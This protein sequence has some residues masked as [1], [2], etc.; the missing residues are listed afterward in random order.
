MKLLSEVTCV[1]DDMEEALRP[2]R[3]R[4]LID[5][6]G[7]SCGAVDEH[8]TS[9]LELSGEAVEENLI[10]R[11]GLS[12]EAVEEHFIVWAGALGRLSRARLWRNLVTV[13]FFWIGFGSA[14]MPR[15]WTFSRRARS[16]RR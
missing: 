8:F 1:Q 16:R 14:W 4:S 10:D 9:G 5:R 11:L 3:D 7:L 6:L 12:C 13:T 15:S 2:M